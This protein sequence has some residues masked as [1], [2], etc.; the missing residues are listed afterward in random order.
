MIAHRKQM[1]HKGRFSCIRISDECH[2]Q[3]A[4]AAS[5]LPLHITRHLYP[6]KFFLKFRDAMRYLTSV[7][8][9]LF[10]TDTFVRAAPATTALTSEML[11][12]SAKAGHHELKIGGLD[13]KSCLPRTG[14][15]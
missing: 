4:V 13:L 6:G 14:S 10:L 3:K 7:E 12:H 1:I 15:P 5:S 9:Y 11:P 8:F 2:V